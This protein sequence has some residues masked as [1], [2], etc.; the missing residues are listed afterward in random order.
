MNE[1]PVG[2]TLTLV[3]KD[4]YSAVAEL[5]SIVKAAG[6]S[7]RAIAEMEIDLLQRK[8][9]DLLNAAAKYIDFR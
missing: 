4:T 2:D 6:W 9:E 1:K 8:G 3:N 7:K 5:R